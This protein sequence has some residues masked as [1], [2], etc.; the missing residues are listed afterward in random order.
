MRKNRAKVQNYPLACD[1]RARWR[2]EIRDEQCPRLERRCP[3]LRL[4]ESRPPSEAPWSSRE[5]SCRQLWPQSRE[6]W[7]WRRAAEWCWW[8]AQSCQAP[9]WP[10]ICITNKSECLGG[11][12]QQSFL[13][14]KLSFFAKTKI[15]SWEQVLQLHF[16]GEKH[17]ESYEL[18]ANLWPCSKVT[19]I[20]PVA[21]H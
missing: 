11:S 12:M 7:H 21:C 2:G 18:I 4:C 19:L 13:F 20:L 14:C 10:E 8:S 15:C 17:N 3:E 9:S 16:H 6:C 5:P 1:R